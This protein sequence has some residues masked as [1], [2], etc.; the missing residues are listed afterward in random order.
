MV[1]KGK[2]KKN[3]KKLWVGIVAGICAF[4][5]AASSFPY[6]FGMVVGEGAPWQTQEADQVGEGELER[7]VEEINREIEEEG[8]TLE[9][10][11]ELSWAY[12]EMARMEGEDAEDPEIGEEYLQKSIEALERGLELDP[13]NPELLLSLYNNY[14]MVGEEEKAE[15]MAEEAEAQFKE[16]LEEEDL[17]EEEARYRFNWGILLWQHQ[18]NYDEAEKQMEKVKELEGED[19][20]LYQQAEMV[21][22]NIQSL[23]EIE[24]EMEGNDQDEM[25]EDS[26]E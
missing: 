16:A 2:P 25:E 8:E 14:N 18:Q 20:E 26:T 1:R 12:Q 13:D 21:L 7:F 4:A 9:R 17:G 22:A 5:L 6:L 11:Q 15:K 19:T 24:E 23:R 3:R 10:L